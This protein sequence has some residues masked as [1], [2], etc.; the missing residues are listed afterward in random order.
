[1]GGVNRQ[2]PRPVRIACP[3]FPAPMRE[4]IVWGKGVRSYD[5]LAR[6]YAARNASFAAAST[7][8][9]ASG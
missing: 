7:R 1:M 3:R 2:P 6:S 5:D 9:T 4:A 8:S